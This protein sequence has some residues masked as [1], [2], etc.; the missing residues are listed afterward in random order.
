VLEIP[1]QVNG[2]LR[3]K[4][5]VDPDATEEKIKQTALADQKVQTL[6]E[7]RQIVKVIFTGKLV[8]IVVR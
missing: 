8:S 3:S 4:I 5:T 6:I 7:G 1:V 2:K